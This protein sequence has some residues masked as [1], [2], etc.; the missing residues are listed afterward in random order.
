MKKTTGEEAT[1][2]PQLDEREQRIN[3]DHAWCAADPEVRRKHGGKI[4]A[5]YNRKVLGV[6]KTYAAAWAA[7]QRRRGC[8]PKH[9]V[10]MVVVPY[11]LPDETAGEK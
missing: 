4:A 5:V 11:R 9:E 7:A 3:A 8:P 10:A 1:L 6:G 2:L